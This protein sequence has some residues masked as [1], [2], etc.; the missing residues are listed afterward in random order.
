MSY[1]LNY[2]RRTSSSDDARF[3][4]KLQEIIWGGK[5]MQKHIV[6]FP[7]W[8]TL[9]YLT[10]FLFGIRGNYRNNDLTISDRSNIDEHRFQNVTQRL[11]HCR[12]VRCN[13]FNGISPVGTEI[14]LTWPRLKADTEA[15]A[16][17]RG[18]NSYPSSIWDLRSHGNYERVYKYVRSCD[19]SIIR[20]FPLSSGFRF[21][22]AQKMPGRQ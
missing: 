3:P 8:E 19:N 21:R 4:H 12:I 9:K 13:F 18:N 14:A 5:K 1:R 16:E 10:D 6:Y 22:I 20:R 11:Y 2:C 17:K 7:N 15:K